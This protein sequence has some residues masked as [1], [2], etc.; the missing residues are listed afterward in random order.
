V[1]GIGA[2]E[3]TGTRDLTPGRSCYAPAR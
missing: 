2:H 1:R 3:A